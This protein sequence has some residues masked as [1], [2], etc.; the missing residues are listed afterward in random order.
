MAPRMQAGNLWT[1]PVVTDWEMNHFLNHFLE[2]ANNSH[3]SKGNQ[4]PGTGLTQSDRGD[5][6]IQVQTRTKN[7]NPKTQV[8]SVLSNTNLGQ[9]YKPTN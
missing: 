6:K 4:P 7:Q 8:Y 2:E 1:P 5:E 9:A 3:R